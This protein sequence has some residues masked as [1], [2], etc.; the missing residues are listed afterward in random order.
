MRK[1]NCLL[2]FVVVCCSVSCT[3]DKYD[4]GNPD[5]LVP[6]R[7]GSSWTY[8][9]T[10]YDCAGGLEESDYSISIDYAKEIDNE[11]WYHLKFDNLW[12]IG[13]DYY[14]KSDKSGFWEQ[15]LSTY[16]GGS[17]TTQ[18]YPVYAGSNSYETITS[19][20]APGYS[21]CQAHD[22]YTLKHVNCLAG[23]Y[24]Y[25]A[26]QYAIDTAYMS[27]NCNGGILLI[28][29]GKVRYISDG[30]GTVKD[31]GYS[32][33]NAYHLSLAPD[34]AITWKDELIRFEY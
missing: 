21:N 31:V 1:L 25:D 33:L 27:G 32:F 2:F 17:S 24:N 19:L 6:M 34:S 9:R 10:C 14:W 22:E 15:I 29:G 11:T 26:Y 8:H 7:V 13:E 28:G 16:H 12:M 23:N 4:I 5:A 30:V 18:F 20:S 3:S